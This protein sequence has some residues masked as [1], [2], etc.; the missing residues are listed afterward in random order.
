MKHNSVLVYEDF[1]MTK[2]DGRTPEIPLYVD[3]TQ[4]AG[5][6]IDIRAK[7]FHAAHIVLPLY[8][9][10]HSELIVYMMPK[11]HIQT[12]PMLQSLHKLHEKNKPSF[13]FE[14]FLYA[15]RYLN[16]TLPA[17]LLRQRAEDIWM[18]LS[19]ETNPAFLPPWLLLHQRVYK[20]AEE[21]FEKHTSCSVSIAACG[22]ASST[23]HEQ[24]QWQRFLQTCVPVCATDEQEISEAALYNQL[25]IEAGGA[26]SAAAKDKINSRKRALQALVNALPKEPAQLLPWDAWELLLQETNGSYEILKLFLGKSL[27]YAWLAQCQSS[28]TAASKAEWQQVLKKEAKHLYH[29]LQDADILKREPPALCEQLK[30]SDM[31]MLLRKVLKAYDKSQSNASFTENVCAFQ[32]LLALPIDGT[33]HNRD[34]RLLLEISEELN[35]PPI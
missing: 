13:S 9:G 17:E 30:E 7:H 28:R 23:T 3:E 16:P 12:Q 14:A 27:L 34:C 10:V 5:Y 20:I 32:R 2:E 4:T 35:I 6:E 19:R 24:E 29:N 1:F 26:D 8:P 21:V 31:E 25:H 18:Q 22:T 11:L 15:L 33:L